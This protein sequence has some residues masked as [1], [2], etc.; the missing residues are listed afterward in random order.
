MT[1]KIYTSCIIHSIYEIHHSD[2]H[3]GVS[4]ISMKDARKMLQ[5]KVLKNL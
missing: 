5:N 4:S 1:D 3:T 2:V